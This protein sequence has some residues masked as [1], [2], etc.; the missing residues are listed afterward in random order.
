[1]E[2][3]LGW[4]RGDRAVAAPH[5]AWAA[6]GLD[7]VPGVA[8]AWYDSIRLDGSE[9]EAAAAVSAGSGR[10]VPEHGEQPALAAAAISGLAALVA[11]V[12]HFLSL[13]VC[14]GR[15]VPGPLKA[16]FL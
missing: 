7:I 5:V 2:C 14:A 1:M 16:C 13:L 4:V 6:R 10:S 3:P 12:P 11:S 15:A 8:A 9:A